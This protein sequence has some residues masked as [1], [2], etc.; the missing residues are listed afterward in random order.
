MATV[1]DEAGARC[2]FFRCD[3]AG[4]TWRGPPG[5]HGP[6]EVSFKVRVFASNETLSVRRRIF[7]V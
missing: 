3:M 6:F 4:W 5:N 1:V 7:T 2:K